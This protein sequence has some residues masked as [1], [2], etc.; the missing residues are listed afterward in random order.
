MKRLKALMAESGAGTQM[1]TDSQRRLLERSSVIAG[2]RRPRSSSGKQR[3]EPLERSEI[4]N[5]AAELFSS[6]GYD[7]TSIRDIAS[8]VGLLPGSIYHHFDSKEE[9]YIAVH[10]GGFPARI[11][12]RQGCRRGSRRPVGAFAPGLVHA[13]P[14]RRPGPH[15][16]HQPGLREQRSLCWRGSSPSAKNTSKSFAS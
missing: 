7:R 1:L 15:H 14:R 3:V 12:A 4:I 11:E 2:L 6:V 8:R 16:R 5:A 13:W 9:L 10:R